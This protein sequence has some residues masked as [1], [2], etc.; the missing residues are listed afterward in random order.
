[1]PDEI[2]T[3]TESTESPAATL[4]TTFLSFDDILS[5][6]TASFEP[7]R[8][9]LPAWSGY[10]LLKPLKEADIL[11]IEKKSSLSGTRDPS[12]SRS[13]RSRKAW[14]SPSS[15]SVRFRSCWSTGAPHRSHNCGPRSTEST[16]WGR[17]RS[18][19][20]TRRF[21]TNP[22]LEMTYLIAERLGKTHGELIAGYS[23]PL[24][25]TEVAYWTAYWQRKQARFACLFSDTLREQMLASATDAVNALCTWAHDEPMADFD[26][27][28][29]HVLNVG[30]E[31]LATWLGQLASAAG[32]RTPACPKCGVHSLN[33]VRRRR[34]PRTLNSRCGTVHI[35]RVRLTCRGCGH[36]WLPLQSVLG[37]AAKT[38]HEWRSPALGS[39]AGWFDHRR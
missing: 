37:L 15:P 30:R 2:T 31:L 16:A 19:T 13:C 39:P 27:R 5:V 1:M 18:K 20:R 10:V 34:K 8:V 33:A 17:R 12:G 7:K 38:A 23:M 22:R 24:A 6:E 11:A 35:P 21:E 32:P 4:E 25:A 29:E 14:S 28:E 9:Y 3:L 26:A 36:S